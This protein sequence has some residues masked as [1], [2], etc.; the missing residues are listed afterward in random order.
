LH[1]ALMAGGA[2]AVDTDL[3]ALS[4]RSGSNDGERRAKIE[5]NLHIATLN[6]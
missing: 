4:Y 5:T 3:R 1:K 6:F 2:S